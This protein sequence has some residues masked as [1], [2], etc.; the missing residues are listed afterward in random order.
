ME[1]ILEIN[2]SNIIIL[3]MNKLRHW[4]IREQSLVLFFKSSLEILSA[5]PWVTEFHFLN[6]QNL[7]L[8]EMAASPP[9]GKENGK[10]QKNKNHLALFP[11]NILLGYP[12]MFTDT[13]GTYSQYSWV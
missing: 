11:S 3:Q 10:N 5:V 4:E 13:K 8:A 6:K 12:V 2:H 9:K 7:C 1:R